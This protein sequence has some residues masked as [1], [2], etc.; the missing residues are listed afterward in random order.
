MFAVKAVLTPPAAALTE[1]ADAPQL[2]P[3]S[4]H[5][6]KTSPSAVAHITL[7]RTG[8]GLTV[9]LFVEARNLSEAE[10]MA[11]A[12]SRS[13]LGEERF[14]GWSLARCE[15]DFFLTVEA[16]EEHGSPPDW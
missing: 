4:R 5:L 12:A 8:V 1:L 14:R 6:L 10:D 3:V 7:R 13:W 2:I 15:G 16:V 11:R 9:M